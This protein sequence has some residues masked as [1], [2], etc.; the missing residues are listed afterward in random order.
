MFEPILEKGLNMLTK[1]QSAENCVAT[2]NVIRGLGGALD[3]KHYK[4]G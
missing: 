4:K 2:D 1:Q 3:L